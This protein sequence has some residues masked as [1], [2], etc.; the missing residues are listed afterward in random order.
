MYLHVLCNF[1]FSPAYSILLHMHIQKP[2]KYLG[3][4]AGISTP[5]SSVLEA[6]VL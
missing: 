2:G 3:T 5:N 1:F 4:T 6:F